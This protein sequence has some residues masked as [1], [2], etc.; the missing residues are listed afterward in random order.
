MNAQTGNTEKVNMKAML[1][2]LGFLLRVYA[3]VAMVWNQLPTKGDLSGNLASIRPLMNFFRILW[4][5][6]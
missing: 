2:R 1:I 6:Y 5:D 4:I 3:Q